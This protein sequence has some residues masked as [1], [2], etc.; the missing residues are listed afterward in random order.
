MFHRLT[1]AALV[2]GAAI[3]LVACGAETEDE[4]AIA[5]VRTWHEAVMDGDADEACAMLTPAG[6]RSLELDADPARFAFLRC[7]RTSQRVDV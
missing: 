3:T 2:C 5:A 1:A 7:H 6:R 4:R